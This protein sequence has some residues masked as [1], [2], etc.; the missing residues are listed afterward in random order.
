MVSIFRAVSIRRSAMSIVTP[1]SLIAKEKI[2]R[3]KKRKEKKE[4]SKTI[5]N[6]KLNITPPTI[7]KIKLPADKT[8]RTVY[9]VDVLSNVLTDYR[10]HLSE[11]L[12]SITQAR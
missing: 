12:S 5:N 4:F 7:V 11:A 1:C 3:E 6:T 10:T 8:T 2:R 9:Y